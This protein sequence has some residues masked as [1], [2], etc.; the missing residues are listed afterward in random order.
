MPERHDTHMKPDVAKSVLNSSPFIFSSA[1]VLWCEDEHSVLWLDHGFVKN[2]FQYIHI[3]ML[4]THIREK[5]RDLS[6]K[7]SFSGG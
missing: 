2:Q 4:N 5:G 3:R 1:F 6:L 7:Y